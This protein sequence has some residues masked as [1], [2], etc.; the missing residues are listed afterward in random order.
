MVKRKIIKNTTDENQEQENGLEDFAQGG[1]DMDPKL[2]R[3]VPP[4]LGC[5]NSVCPS[6]VHCGWS[7]GCVTTKDAYGKTGLMIDDGVRFLRA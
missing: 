7:M 6:W 4:H 3:I 1:D 2:P 5:G